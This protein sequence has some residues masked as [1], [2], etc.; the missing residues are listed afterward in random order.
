MNTFFTFIHQRLPKRSTV[1]LPIVGTLLLSL[2]S[3]TLTAQDVF[4]PASTASHNYGSVG[5]F[6]FIDIDGNGKRDAA[7]IPLPNSTVTLFDSSNNILATRITNSN[8]YFI[9]D[10]IEIPVIGYRNLKV[11]FESPSKEYTFTTPNAD[12]SDSS[13]SS[14]ADPVSGFSSLFILKAGESKLTLNAGLKPAAGVLLPVTIH[15]FTGAYANGFVELSWKAM[16]NTTVKHFD[17]ER[18][19]DGI[20]F[21]QIGQVVI[22]EDNS[23][24]SNFTY[25]D[26]L[27]EKGSNFYRLVIVDKDGNYTYSKEITIS[28]EAKGISLMVVYP[29]PFSKRV[30][31]K[32]DCDNAEMVT[33]RIVDN[34]GNV[35]R[36]QTASLQKGENRMAINN[37][38]EL[39][40]GF[41]YLEVIAKDRKMRIKLM[42]QK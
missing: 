30:Q 3:F 31:V 20:N 17:I 11:R 21:R 25:L 18:S 32:I 38:D 19:T 28:V 7:D 29:N 35:A 41:Y 13:N 37:V 36:T 10:S 2:I 27:A 22:D 26:I 12:G 5:Q 8:G 1:A 34:F 9:F 33:I 40:S 42:K 4:K 6:V 24:I 23:S 14:I 16:V 39:P 15:Q